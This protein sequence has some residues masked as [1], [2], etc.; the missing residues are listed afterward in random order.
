MLSKN[1]YDVGSA[2]LM[3]A[4]H[5]VMIRRDYVEGI[6]AQ[7]NNEKQMTNFG[8]SVTLS[9]EDCFVEIFS[10]SAHFH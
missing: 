9:M 1:C 5:N 4:P 6:S 7:F 8:Q 10:E 2:S 3:D